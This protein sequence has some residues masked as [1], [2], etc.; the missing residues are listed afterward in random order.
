MKKWQEG[1]R[2]ERYFRRKLRREKSA[3][4]LISPDRKR[5]QAL[6][7]AAWRRKGK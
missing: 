1:D 7:Y 2:E 6:V 5:D 4:S 3:E